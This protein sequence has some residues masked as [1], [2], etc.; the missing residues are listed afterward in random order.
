MT[1]PYRL[2]AGPASL[3]GSKKPLFDT[4]T[5]VCYV[6]TLESDRK[7]SDLCISQFFEMKSGRLF[8]RK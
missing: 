2:E 7:I 8:I 6:N 5:Q 1:M 4:I 3:P